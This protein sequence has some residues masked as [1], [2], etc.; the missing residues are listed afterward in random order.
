M[1][2]KYWIANNPNAEVTDAQATALAE[3]NTTE[4]DI[5]DGCTATAAELN[6]NDNQVASVTF[7]VAAEGGEAIVVSCQFK[8]AA[9]ADMTTASA[10][11]AFLSADSSSQT[12]A[13]ASGLTPSAGTDGHVIPIADSNTA[14]A[15]LLISEADG[16]V[17]V[18]I[19]DG[20]GGTTTNYLN[21]VTPSG[22]IYTSAAITFAA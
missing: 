22:K 6:L 13:S 1:A 14:V 10:C 8:D 3:L 7:S 2:N 12:N 11:Y 9:G 20:S 4:L 21:V 17:D 18:T 19:T 16:D 5:L 15:M